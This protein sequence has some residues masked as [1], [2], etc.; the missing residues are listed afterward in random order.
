LDIRRGSERPEDAEGGEK[1]PSAPEGVGKF[2]LGLLSDSHGRSETTRRAASLLVAA[3]ADALIHLGDVGSVQV[4]EALV[5]GR[6]PT[7]RP[8]PPVGLVWGNVDL[9]PARLEGRCRDLGITVHRGL[10]RI[11]AGGKSALF[12]H[13]HEKDVFG[14]ALSEAPDYL[15]H[16]H[17]HQTR[18]DLVNRTRV[19][20]PGAL[21]RAAKYT[22]AI[23]DLQSDRVEFIEVSRE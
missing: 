17:T 20:N 2:R 5:A 6:E 13:G 14:S 1:I 19:I 12:L 21:F 7:G 4:L 11:E 9:S 16:G 15:F 18:N 3:G 23:V 22:V 10:G 8:R